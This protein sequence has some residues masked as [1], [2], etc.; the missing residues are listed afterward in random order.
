M[1]ECNVREGA[2]PV[3][4]DTE[5]VVRENPKAV[6]FA[7]VELNSPDKPQKT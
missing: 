2:E 5:C 7:L 4:T 1:T 3:E 6:S